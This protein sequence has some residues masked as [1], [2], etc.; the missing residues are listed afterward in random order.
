MRRMAQKNAG[1]RGVQPFP[2]QDGPEAIGVSRIV[3]V[4][5]DQLQAINRYHS[6]V[7]HMN[8]RALHS[9]DKGLRVGKFFVVSCNE[10]L[11]EL[12]SD[13]PPGRS[14]RLGIYSSTVI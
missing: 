6:I 8:S 4:D 3:I 9:C 13:V 1:Y 12:G 10:I 7:Q 11:A 14:H 5:S 2:G